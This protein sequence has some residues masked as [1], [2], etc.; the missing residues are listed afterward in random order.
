MKIAVGKA[1]RW[2][3][4]VALAF[5]CTGGLAGLPVVSA[6]G[7]LSLGTLVWAAAVAR[8]VSAAVAQGD[9][10]VQVGDG[11]GEA[12]ARVGRPLVL[13]LRLEGAAATRIDS[14]TLEAGVVAPARA[15]VSATDDGFELTV[16][17]PQAGHTW[18]QG[19]RFHAEIAG[20]L[21]AL[22]GWLP[23]PLAIS[24]LPRAFPLRGDPPLRATRAASQDRAELGR[25]RRRGFGLE[26]RELR[27]HQPGDPFKHIAW[28]ATA[29]RGKLVSREFESDLVLSAWLLVDV[30]P[31]MFWGEPG[32]T[33]ADFA[34]ET[35]YNLAAQLLARGDRVGISLYDE[36]VRMDIPPSASR[37]QLFRVLEALQ[38]VH[39]LFHEDRTEV[40][41]RELVGAVAG[42]FETQQ[43]RTFR[44]PE[45]LTGRAGPRQSEHDEPRLQEA[46]EAWL[47][48]A[49]QRRR[50]ARFAIPLDS[51]A[52]DRRRSTWRAFC[53][54]AGIA[55]P[56]DPTPRPG[57]Q[58]HGIEQAV[59][60]VLRARG[61]PH[62][63]C[64]I[65]DLST[66]DDLDALRRAALGARRHRHGLLVLCPS[67]PAFEGATRPEDGP[68]AEALL[69]VQRIRTRHSLAA[70]EAALRP[71]GVA[72]V[73]CTPRDVL[74][75]LLQRLD[76]VA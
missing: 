46:A 34:L 70:V 25:A 50:P 10:R 8:L 57:G 63:L 47:Q 69:E 43:G 28:A 41:Q 35:A 54:H 68:L 21:L 33:R 44:L 18:L 51:Y 52:R 75:R 59:E 24:V 39:H 71:A 2:V 37:G 56:L 16:E 66:A 67:D 74:P 3:L 38:E 64:A 65:S 30:S 55:L 60:H 14:V 15:A 22:R 53:R 40:T 62:T 11:S 5:L 26:I 29:R 73:S 7:A 9:L 32:H 61:G 4:G 76:Q 42:W 20:G 31:S 58:A 19:F 13:P 49:A 12:R 48:Q 17:A 23:S 36:R 45:S 1:G 72:L 6:L 27:D